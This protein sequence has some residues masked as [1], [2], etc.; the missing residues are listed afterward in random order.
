MRRRP[1]VE[2]I[3]VLTSFG[4]LLIFL[5]FHLRIVNTIRAKGLG[6]ALRVEPPPG[7]PVPLDP[8]REFSGP[9]SSLDLP[10]LLEIAPPDLDVGPECFF[11]PAALEAWRERRTAG[12]LLAALEPPVELTAHATDEGVLLAWKPPPRLGEL[13]RE[14]G[15]STRLELVWRVY[16]W[17]P[18]D[19][20][21]LLDEVPIDTDRYLDR[22]LGPVGGRVFYSVF[23]AL[24][25]R[26]GGRDTLIQSES[27]RAIEIHVPDR[28]EIVLEGL[29]GDSGGEQA[30]A[31]P[32]IRLVV[33]RTDDPR[34]ASTFVVGE[35]EPVGSL[36]TNADGRT[37]DL[38]TGFVVRGIAIRT[39][40]RRVTVRRPVFEPD[41]SRAFDPDRG[42]L[43]REEVRTIPARRLEVTLERPG[44]TRVLEIDLPPK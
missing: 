8:L 29:A 33:R 5:G 21:R 14:V 20:P 9:L 23:T 4:L 30:S 6:A 19:D 35:G 13:Q 1:S 7:A 36:V 2:R 37:L 32:K 28:N 40:E 42:F 26:I 44:E 34:S 39:V 11:P 24:K 15:R 18:G 17:R 31:A 16:R 10:D 38:R 3:A 22:G 27:S 43:F 25:G 41:G 12:E